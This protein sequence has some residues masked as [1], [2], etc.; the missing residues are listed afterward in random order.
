MRS[1]KQA[2]Q[3][4]GGHGLATARFADEA[5][6]LAGIHVERHVAGNGRRRPVTVPQ[7]DGEAFDLEKAFAWLA[8]ISHGVSGRA[9][10]AAR[11][12]GD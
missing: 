9:R 10:R 7:H 3:R 8:G 6:D 1:G 2:D 12:P 11:L 4:L 5:D